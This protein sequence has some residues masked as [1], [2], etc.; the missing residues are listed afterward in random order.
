MPPPGPPTL[1]SQPSPPT[2][3][4]P[5]PALGM[6]AIASTV[7][8]GQS[9][10]LLS[11]FLGY[12]LIRAPFYPEQPQP[13]TF[14]LLSTGKAKYNHENGFVWTC[15]P[16][17]TPGQEIKDLPGPRRSGTAQGLLRNF[18]RK[19][20]IAGVDDDTQTRQAF[21]TLVDLLS[22]V[23]FT[24]EHAQSQMR[25]KHQLHIKEFEAST[26]KSRRLQNKLTALTSPTHMNRNR[27]HN[28]N[29]ILPNIEKILHTR[30]YKLLTMACTGKC[31]C[32]HCG[33]TC[34][35]PIYDGTQEFSMRCGNN[36]SKCVLNG[37]HQV[38]AAIQIFFVS[39]TLTLAFMTSHN[40]DKPVVD[41]GTRMTAYREEQ[42]RIG[43]ALISTAQ[44]DSEK[45]TIIA[46][47]P[48]CQQRAMTNAFLLHNFLTGSQKTIEDDRR[49]LNSS[50]KAV[51][52]ARQPRGSYIIK[53]SHAKDSEEMEQYVERSERRSLPFVQNIRFDTYASETT[54][55]KPSTDTYPDPRMQVVAFSVE[56]ENPMA[57][58]PLIHV[59][60]P[61]PRSVDCTKHFSDLYS[62]GCQLERFLSLNY[63]EESVPSVSLD[64]QHSLCKH[65]LTMHM[66]YY[67]V[68]QEAIVSLGSMF[69]GKHRNRHAAPNSNTYL[70][71][72]SDYLDAVK[73]YWPTFTLRIRK[74]VGDAEQA[75][76]KGIA[77]F[78]IRHNHSIG[79]KQGVLPFY[80]MSSS[81]PGQDRTFLEAVQGDG[82]YHCC[83]VLD[84]WHILMDIERHSVLFKDREA[85][86][87]FKTAWRKMLLT[88]DTQLWEIN[89]ERL[90][91][92]ASNLPD[93]QSRNLVGVLSFYA[94]FFQSCF[95]IYMP[96]DSQ[97]LAC[98]GSSSEQWHGRLWRTCGYNQTLLRQVT[99]THA[100]V[101]YLTKHSKCA[102]FGSCVD[103]FLHCAGYFSS[104][105]KS[106]TNVCTSKEATCQKSLSYSRSFS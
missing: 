49:V 10:E 95:P 52:M 96:S 51:C 91:L 101:S 55:S 93:A 23:P 104:R 28:V 80:R 81:G 30:D 34:M 11:E 20:N 7:N 57:C 22:S 13:N 90:D 50:I 27:E 102:N 42:Q 73:S 3:P 78:C 83:Q 84:K 9:Q 86:Q 71:L 46:P 87:A 97:T 14:Y 72:L 29:P 63:D 66:T 103:H 5:P 76:W 56:Y 43:N 58:S 75:L 99:M 4:A 60:G 77:L 88:H 54:L 24:F 40:C 16:A 82:H 59:N 36:T 68:E 8:A 45:N 92:Q 106:F 67:D 100:L 21:E 85:R 74:F 15:P 44:A 38:C 31:D 105:S 2:A 32:S 89:K 41:T 19:S 65:Y 26:P 62:K 39:K 33:P 79:T 98:A 12:S 64:F 25:K 61:L 35:K 18:F 37:N 70:G 48:F 47:I 53:F 1:S 69:L 6:L 94:D 17:Y